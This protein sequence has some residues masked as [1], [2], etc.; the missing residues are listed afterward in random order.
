MHCLFQ[1]LDVNTV[2]FRFDG[3]PINEVDTPES[4][5]MDDGDTIEVYLQQTGGMSECVWT[6]NLKS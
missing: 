2:R 4:L 3:E 1:N 5:E 6:L